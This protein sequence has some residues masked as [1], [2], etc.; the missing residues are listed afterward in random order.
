VTMTNENANKCAQTIER[1]CHHFQFI[2][3]AAETP[4]SAGKQIQT[5]STAICQSTGQLDGTEGE[6]V[7]QIG[8]SQ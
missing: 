8:L 6:S 1:N 5:S 3:N 7:W 4:A 2:I